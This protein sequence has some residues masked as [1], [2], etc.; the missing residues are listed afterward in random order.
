[1]Q[2]DA[3]KRKIMESEIKICTIIVICSLIKLNYYENTKTF[4]C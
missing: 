2:E 4:I 3:K 1:M